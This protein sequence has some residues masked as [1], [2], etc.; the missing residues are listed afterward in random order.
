MYFNNL[1]LNETPIIKELCKNII[2]DFLTNLK[3]F[4]INTEYNLLHDH[5]SNYID[6]ETLTSK[7]IAL[8]SMSNIHYNEY[9]KNILN[10]IELH[11]DYHPLI[12]IC[13]D[14]IINHYV[15]LSDKYKWKNGTLI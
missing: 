12:I 4:N 6:N 9:Y 2:E 15:K 3:S 8:N 14:I 1:N 11:Y 13:Y 7:N 10:K 5:I